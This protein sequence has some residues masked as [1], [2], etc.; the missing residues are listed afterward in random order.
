MRT[1]GDMLQYY[2]IPRRVYP[3]KTLS[4]SPTNCVLYSYA[5]SYLEK[6]QFDRAE[7]TNFP[8]MQNSNESNA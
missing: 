5:L 1:A 8:D 4:L 6:E 3:E 7:S 2:L